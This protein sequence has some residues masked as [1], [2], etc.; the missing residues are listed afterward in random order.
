MPWAVYHVMINYLNVNLWK[1]HGSSLMML[2]IIIEGFN[3]FN[4][5]PLFLVRL[6]YRYV[7]NMRK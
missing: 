5:F 6:R 2:I 3:Y 7:M 1:G 4:S